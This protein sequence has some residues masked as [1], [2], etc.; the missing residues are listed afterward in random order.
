[1]DEERGLEG[2]LGVM[3]IAKHAAANA[4]N[5]R[6]VPPQQG[7]EGSGIP[8][9]DEVLQELPIG[10]SGPVLMEHRPPQVLEEWLASAPCHFTS[11]VPG[12]RTSLQ[13]IPR[14]RAF[15]SLFF[16]P[17]RIAAMAVQ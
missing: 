10:Q 8:V 5:H 14:S 12:P 7:L 11:S 3:H 1:Q 9:A 15:P 13:N 17:E 6:A 16:L 2:V 4:Q